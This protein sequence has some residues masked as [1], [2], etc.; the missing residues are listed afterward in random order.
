M[1]S[2]FKKFLSK[3]IPMKFKILVFSLT[4]A[5][6]ASAFAQT[7]KVPVK[8]KAVKKDSPP[9]VSPK[10][11]E[12]PRV[13]VI[14]GEP[15]QATM[16]YPAIVTIAPDPFR[17]VFTDGEKLG[18]RKLAEI[19]NLDFSKIKTFSLQNRYAKDFAEG[20]LAPLIAK[21]FNESPNLE[22][23]TLRYI[24]LKTLPAIT[25]V[26]ANL[27][28]LDLERNELTVLPAGLENLTN[29]EKLNLDHNQLTT[30]PDA[31]TKLRKLNSISLGHNSFTKFPEQ[32]FSIPSLTFFSVY[33][34]DINMLPDQFNQLPNL[35]ALSVQKTKIATLPP[36]FST[37]LKLEEV[38]LSH[39]EFKEFPASI[40][41]LKD[42]IKVDLSKNPLDKRLFMQSIANIKW[43]G[44]LSLYDVP[45]TKAEYE[46]VSAKL[47]LMDVYY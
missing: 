31:L 21:L 19:E 24:K 5:L 14:F 3:P 18:S 6:S 32:M 42:L 47:K 11:N 29:L 9:P 45:F 1:P 22:Q 34:S 7:K 43:R 25:N 44:L 30:L 33:N 2:S 10:V 26:N 20:E 12:P 15:N 46:A 23:L 17:I 16:N 28:Q 4:I 13:E 27:K 37:L 35:T 40:A 39:N 41:G 38:Y 8:K 36:T